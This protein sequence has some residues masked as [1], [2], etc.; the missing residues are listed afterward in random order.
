[1]KKT[2][3]LLF[4][5]ITGFFGYSQV[6][7]QDAAWPNGS[8]TVTGTYNTDP[9]A[10]EADPTTTA[11]FAFDDDDAGNGNDD[12]IAAESPVIDLTAAAGAGETW[13][14]VS[15]TY[16]YYY[17][18]EDELVFQY[19]DADA[20][21]WVN[22]G[23][24]FDA[25][26]TTTSLFDD[27]CSGTYQAY[28]TSV[29]DISSFTATQLSGFRYRISYDDNPAGDDWN[30]GFCFTSPTITSA[31][32]PSCP[33]PSGLTVTPTSTT[34]ATLNWTAGSTETD[35]TYEYGVTGFTLG[36]GTTGTA[37]T[38]P[39]ANISGLTPGT[40]YDVYVQANC[41]GGNGDSNFIGPITWTQPNLGEDCGVAFVATSEADCS[42][43]TPLSL[44]FT[45]GGI[46]VLPGCD[47]F[48]NVGYWVE[49]TIPAN[50]SININLAGTATDVGVAIFDACGGT[51]VFCNNNALGATTELTGFTP[52]ATYYFYFWQDTANGTADIC[53]EEISC[54]F[55]SN[56]GASVTSA[57]SADISW[58]ENN[59]PAA[60]AWE[61][62]VQAPG[63]GV[64][65]GAGTATSSNPTSVTTG[66]V[67]GMDYEFYV[68]ANCG[69]S[70]SEWSGPFT[71]TQVVP[72]ANDDCANAIPL[73]PGVVYGD[74]P[75]D[76]TVLGA[77]DSGTTNGCGLNGPDVWYSV[78]VPADGNITI[79]TGD[80]SGG[81]MDFDSVIEAFSGTCG[82]LTSIECDDDGSATGSY[83]LLDLT[84]LTPG[85]T[86]YI[87]VWEY[88]GDEAEPFS[89]SAYSATLSVDEA[90]FE[91]FSYY[92][93]PV[94]NT[95]TIDAQD[96]IE[97]ITMY[98]ILGQEVLRSKPNTIGSE[99]DMSSLE[100]GTYFARVTIAGASKTI[101][102]I[103]Q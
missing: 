38:A 58:D 63:T 73:T 70:F 103:K 72:P 25:L 54:V 19:W 98:N 8:W 13:I 31:T 24:S 36:A 82:A 23:M 40:D 35:W 71:W 11:N 66:L 95:L 5:L 65:G 18:A 89:I 52:S 47:G 83:S 17:L 97:A 74:N 90:V 49:L 92:P 33:D 4:F 16:V 61:Y 81:G 30:Y 42:T 84:G 12:D 2:T 76:S 88:N 43:A 50:G 10:F 28:T 3:I 56:L 53:F 91:N 6:L 15:T 75:V 102:I 45:A 93:N 27:F 20:S 85:S 68:R 100:T 94:K 86:I 80:T 69:G 1:M 77:T 60:T 41:G 79:E 59:S 96:T 55:P 32:P 21:S 99:V 51:E 34:D 57:T 78:V 87:R 7:N 26:G 29:L 48:G 39:T 67:E 64:P 22:W 101:R 44:D 37:M 62:V 9:T 46:E 14:T